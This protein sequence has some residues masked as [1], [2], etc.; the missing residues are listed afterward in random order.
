MQSM[1]T[2][3]ID[4]QEQNRVVLREYAQL[5]GLTVREAVDGPSGL[6]S[7]R[8]EPPDLVLLDFNM[9]GMNGLEVLGAMKS[10]PE[11]APIPVIIITAVDDHE[12]TVRCIERGAEDYLVKPFSPVL[13]RA[14]THA[15]LERKRLHDTERRRQLELERSSRLKTTLLRIASHDLRNPLSVVLGYTDLLLRK[16]PIGTPMNA[17]CYDN[18]QT[19]RQSVLR[20]NDLLDTFLSYQRVQAGILTPRL[21]PLHAGAALDAAIAVLADQARQKRISLIQ[22]KRTP[23]LGV[24][25]DSKYL[26]QSLVNCLSNA[27]KYAP[28]GSTVTA[29]MTS[30][31]EAVRF[32]VQDEGPG[33]LP[34]D[35]E[36]LFEEFADVG[37]QPTAG[38]TSTGLGL[39]IVRSLVEAQGGRIG[40][41]FP[42]AGGS[43]FWFCL[44]LADLPT[45]TAREN[46]LG[47][48]SAPQ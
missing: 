19:I 39:Y 46:L 20:M 11:L 5:L 6:A 14:R 7:A 42:D 47:A 8:A 9:P 17:R 36:K 29:G 26:Q 25:A 40:A 22:K 43:C 12:H 13:L 15:C 35:R 16:V 10:D 18:L 45:H 38:E 32:Y 37:T 3:I 33:I 48:G 2:L 1:S 27:I 30:E 4:D 23:P 28:P 31:A 24:Q 34:A 41:D 21:E 44:P